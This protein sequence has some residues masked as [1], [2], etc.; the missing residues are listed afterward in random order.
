VPS[1]CCPTLLLFFILDTVK[2]NNYLLIKFSGFKSGLKFSVEKNGYSAAD[3]P[4]W[5]SVTVYGLDAD[6]IKSLSV[7]G[8]DMQN[9]AIYDKNV[10]VLRITGLSLNVNEEHEIEWT[11]PHQE[12]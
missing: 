1:E 6:D 11:L 9:K 12:L 10:K 3:L 7:D 5:G 8:Q 4:K 2:N